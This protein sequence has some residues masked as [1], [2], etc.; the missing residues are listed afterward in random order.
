MSQLARLGL[1]LCSAVL[2][3]GPAD[4]GDGPGAPDGSASEPPV[5][6]IDCPAAAAPRLSA[7]GLPLIESNPGGAVALFLDFDGGSYQGSAGTETYRGYSRDSNFA[8]FT[9]QEQ[10]DIVTSMQFVNRS[11]AM[12]NVNVTTDD[13][14]RL[15]TGK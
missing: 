2:A 1:F 14:A 5:A 10:D 7:A 4:T 15:R 9:K 13:T 8:T 11:F 6:A 12:F 3:C